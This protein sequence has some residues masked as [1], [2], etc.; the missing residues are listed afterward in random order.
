MEQP[1][2]YVFDLFC[3]EKYILDLD[4]EAE[5]AAE[6]QQGH[7]GG[8][9]G[10]DTA[11]GAVAWRSVTLP[12]RLPRWALH[13]KGRGAAE[14]PAT[15]TRLQLEYA[16]LRLPG[17][18][19]RLP[20]LD[21]GSPLSRPL[22]CYGHGGF[23][24]AALSMLADPVWATLL[25]A[26]ERKDDERLQAYLAGLSGLVEDSRAPAELLRLML[27]LENS[28]VLCAYGLVRSGCTRPAFEAARALRAAA[29]GLAVPP[30]FVWQTFGIP[31]HRLPRL[32]QPLIDH[33][34]QQQQQQMADAK[35]AAG[36]GGD[37]AAAA[38]A[39]VGVN[40]YGYAPLGLEWDL[41]LSPDDP[42][43]AG[44]RRSGWDSGEGVV[45]RSR[46]A[47]QAL[48]E[49]DPVGQLEERQREERARQAEE[50]E[51]ARRAEE[52]EEEAED[53]AEFEGE[54]E[55]AREGEDGGGG[56]GG[57]E[58]EL[59]VDAVYD[60]EDGAAAAV[61]AGAE[62]V[63][64]EV[65]GGDGDGG[66]DRL[67]EWAARRPGV[68]LVL[69]FETLT[70]L[71]AAQSL[72]PELP[73][74]LMQSCVAMMAAP[75]GLYLDVKSG[76]SSARKLRCFAAALAGV[77][78]ICSF[79][80]S[81]IDFGDG[82]PGRSAIPDED[83]EQA[84]ATVSP[85]PGGAPSGPAPASL[86][87]GRADA[88]PTLSSP[89]SVGD[90]IADARGDGEGGGRGRAAGGAGPRRVFDSVLFF[91]GL[92]GLEL[93]CEG[94]RVP[95]GTC[96]LFNGASMLLE[97]QGAAIAAAAAAA[98]ATDV[99]PGDG[100]AGGGAK[101]GGGGGGQHEEDDG[102][103]EALPALVDTD[104]WRRYCT[105]VSICKIF[106]GIY[107]QEP[108]CCP[109]AVDA[110]IRLTNANPD[111]LPLGFAY[112]HLSGKVVAFPGHSG[113]GLAAQQ[114]LEELHSRKQ[115]GL[116]VGPG[117][118]VGGESGRVERWILGGVHVGAGDDVYLSW[119]RRLLKGSELMY[120]R[121]QLLLLRLLADFD[122]GG[123]G[124]VAEG[125]RLLG[126]MEGLGGLRFVFLRF[127]EHYRA[128]SPLTLFEY[129]FNL[130]YTK[131]LLR[132]LRNRGALA[133]LPPAEKASLA[134]WL[135]SCRPLRL[136]LASLGWR[137]SR[138]KHVKEALTC[139][140]ESCN[141]E[142]YGMVCE[143][144]GGEHLLLRAL[145]GWYGLSLSG[146]SYRARL[147]EAHRHWAERPGG[148]LVGDGCCRY[149]FVR[150]AR[151]LPDAGGA[152][153]PGQGLE[154]DDDGGAAGGGGGSSGKGESKGGKGGGGA[155]RSVPRVWLGPD[156]V[157]VV[158]DPRHT[159]EK[160]WSL[161]LW[162]LVR[163]S[164][165][166][167]GTWA[168]QAFLCC[169]CGYMSCGLYWLFLFPLACYPYC[170]TRALPLLLAAV[171]VGLLWW[172]LIAAIV[173]G[174]T[175]A[176]L[177]KRQEEAG[178][179]YTDVLPPFPPGLAPSAPPA[180]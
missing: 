176:R 109:A 3:K 149:G 76:Y 57:R 85:E 79:V 172:S 40:R 22:H 46:A 156:G 175:A 122:C 98:A 108:D 107:V 65:G 96:V 89:L 115:L 73:P 91:H 129:G 148:S 33:Q 42:S 86:V 99:K 151:R 123:G 106:G 132:L 45:K 97:D 171:L 124:P 62:G 136:L 139:L 154:G 92:N 138:H 11:G 112:G 119:G 31:P 133:A 158:S 16:L 54:G 32:L 75:G 127:H 14:N 44:G 145:S 105:L 93:A 95:P 178:G 78:A 111:Y 94:G 167:L 6:A 157:P 30:S 179:G 5:D 69:R 34:A 128:T 12:L 82:P 17:Q 101:A 63:R 7:A 53:R 140:A 83:G 130:N 74:A 41:W 170:R 4:R 61:A 180:R 70:V 150:Y 2:N 20:E 155:R 1:K 18:L 51:R 102:E 66:G 64:L 165:C 144:L 174:V 35:T 166:C 50:E 160:E 103:G 113:R 80:P 8:G 9:L 81:Q 77:G 134:S 118:V 60:D 38:T 164:S 88:G 142:E 131:P 173:S 177:A 67:P 125:S 153:A 39:V 169:C 47:E 117:G 84:P 13:R 126:L 159:H 15:V 143:A 49:L 104:A 162:L 68:S 120:M 37:A 114:L 152:F 36:G 87:A 121:Q 141:R 24:G 48:A 21:L 72:H 43:G 110:L 52:A 135:A 55:G 29:A 25:E 56:D 10:G 116:M 27:V 163:K 71:Q 168:V 147:R 146:W 23:M 90:A 26:V 161:R 100:G 19:A 137:A 28:P 58:E 59:V